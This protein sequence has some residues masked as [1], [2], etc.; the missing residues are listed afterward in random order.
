MSIETRWVSRESIAAL[1]TLQKNTPLGISS[2]VRACIDAYRLLDAIDSVF[3]GGPVTPVRELLAK[4]DQRKWM[5]KETIQT[6]AT[7]QHNRGV[8][9]PFTNTVIAAYKQHHA[10]TCLLGAVAPEVLEKIRGQHT[11]YMRLQNSTCE[12]KGVTA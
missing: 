5:S 11:K 1:A 12:L 3:A 9:D 2:V 6:L 10:A 7:A 8:Y 4:I